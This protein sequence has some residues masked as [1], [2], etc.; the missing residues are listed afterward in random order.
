MTVSD[1]VLSDSE[2]FTW[3]IERVNQPPVL[4][5]PANRTSMEGASISFAFAASDPD[6]DVLVYS[7]TGLPPSMVLDPATGLVTGTLSYTSAG[8]YVVSVTFR[9]GESGNQARSPGWS[10]N[11][12]RAPVLVNPG[13]QSHVRARR[14]C[15]GGRC[16]IGPS[17]YWRLGELSGQIGR[18]QRRVEAGHA[19][20]QVIASDNRARWPTA[21]APWSSTG[22]SGYIQVPGAATL[23]LAGDLTI[24][25]WVNRVAWR[26]GRR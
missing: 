9:T 23:P 8:E 11:T 4:E 14:V 13:A 16:T 22:S 10:S 6:G 25:L 17:A 5:M 3:T 1:G 15:D 20:G 12:N 21:T 18:G 26:A 2:S 24:E 7:A 19:D